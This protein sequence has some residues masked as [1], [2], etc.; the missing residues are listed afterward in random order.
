MSLQM[1]IYTQAQ[2]MIDRFGT[3]PGE[4]AD[5]MLQLRLEED[6]LLAAGSWLAIGQAIEDLARLE[7][8]EPRH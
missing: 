2:Q 4:Y 8:G 1:S 5:A 3:E 7:A 6:D